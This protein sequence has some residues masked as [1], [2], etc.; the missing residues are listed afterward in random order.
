MAALDYCTL[1]EVEAYAGVNFSDGIGPT[2]SEVGTMITNASRLLDSYAG[3]QLA[4][5]ETYT[6]WFDATNGLDRVV[7]SNRPVS[8]VTSLAYVKSDGTEESQLEGRKR[9]G[10]DEWWLDDGDAGIIR[11]HGAFNFLVG[12][13]SNYIKVVYVAG[14]SAAPAD[15]KMACIM[16]V[17]RQCARAAMNDENCMDRVKE[18]WRELLKDSN[19]EYERL[20]ERVKRKA[21]VDVAVFGPYYKG[22]SIGY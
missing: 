18:F 15:V 19:R 10:K 2:D 17:V 12:R 16:L 4:G 14:H 20:L 6:E 5:T 11:L 1:A 22:G 7:L 21:L 13:L 9:D 8:S 3:F